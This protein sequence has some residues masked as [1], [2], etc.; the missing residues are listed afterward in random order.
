MKNRS[1]I[2]NKWLKENNYVLQKL[3]ANVLSIN[4]NTEFQSDLQCFF[5]R[6]RECED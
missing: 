6:H 1:E 2:Y 5:K 4:T 3:R